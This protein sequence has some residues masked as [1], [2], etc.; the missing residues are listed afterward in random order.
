MNSKSTILWNS[1]S[2][3]SK[4]TYR[5][6]GEM[7]DALSE[8]E[9]QTRPRAYLDTRESPFS[10]LQ[11]EIR[12]PFE[13]ESNRFKHEQK[14]SAHTFHDKP[15]CP[16]LRHICSWTGVYSAPVISRATRKSATELPYWNWRAL[17]HCVGRVP[18]TEKKS[19]ALHTFCQLPGRSTARG[20]S[21]G[22]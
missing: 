11:Q 2:M 1:S 8:Q 17:F 20:W 9:D 7:S 15:N 6:E 4:S 5:Q 10:K 18:P 14:N 19:K 21:M 22:I 16:M 13:R 12:R 3:L